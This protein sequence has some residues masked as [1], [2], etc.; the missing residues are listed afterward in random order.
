MAGVLVT[1]YTSA[2][3]P[4]S[5][6]VT[7]KNGQYL[8]TN[9][10]PGNYYIGF[11][12]T[13]NGSLF[14]TADQGGNDGLDSDVNNTNGA[15]TTA[16]FNVPQASVNITIDAGLL[17][18]Q[19]LPVQLQ[20]MAY[21]RNSTSE[22]IWKVSGDI[23]DAKNYVVERSA[24]GRNYTS[25]ISLQA[26]SR[27]EYQQMDLQPV[28]GINYYRIRIEYIN[29]KTEYSE[30][31]IIRFDN[32]G[33][34]TIFPNPAVS[35]VNINLPDSWQG[36]KVNME[37]INQLGQV[38]IRKSQNQASQVETIDVSR[39]ARSAYNLKLVSSNQKVEVRK[40]QVIH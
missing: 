24:D 17:Y 20:F 33:A 27:T 30:V 31:R 32:N 39:L 4:V 12:N 21:K 1:V 18:T 34:I 35:T 23:S 28:I 5:T 15:G 19:V 3:V 37:I 14:V 29:G 13:P 11:T 7:D 25:I 16:T 2:G 26:D 10:P 36:K 6:T 38:V 40:I 22:L 8:F 9:V